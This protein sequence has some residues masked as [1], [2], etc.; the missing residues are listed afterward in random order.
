M[1]FAFENRIPCGMCSKKHLIESMK[2]DR[3]GEKMLCP[4]C[5][6]SQFNRKGTRKVME[7]GSVIETRPE[8]GS[9][10][11]GNPE[12]EKRARTERMDHMLAYKCTHCQ[13][14]FKRRRSFPFRGRCPYCGKDKVTYDPIKTGQWVEKLW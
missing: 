11:Y 2:V 6:D 14:E 12:L 10:A 1:A 9:L 4:T 8:K 13:Y 5:S 3:Y 7:D